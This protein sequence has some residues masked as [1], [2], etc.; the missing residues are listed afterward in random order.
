MLYNE[1]HQFEIYVKIN[2]K[3]SIEYELLLRDG[4]RLS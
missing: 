4:C 2:P 3:A 1:R